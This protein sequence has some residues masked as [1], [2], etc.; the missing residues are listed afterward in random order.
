MTDEVIEEVKDMGTE[1][2]R[3]KIRTRGEERV[4]A[5]ELPPYTLVPSRLRGAYT[6][7][8]LTNCLF[9]ERNNPSK[10]E[11]PR[12]YNV[13]TLD[14]YDRKDKELYSL[15]R[16]YVS[17]GDPTEYDVAMKVFGS[18][19]HWE[20]LCK[21]NWFKPYLKAM[22][23]E[24]RSKIKSEA[25]KQLVEVSINS[26]SDTVRATALRF[27]AKEKV[28]TLE[29]ERNEADNPFVSSSGKR[30]RPSKE[31]IEGNLKQSADEEKKLLQDYERTI[32]LV[33]P[34]SR[35]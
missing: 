18:V 20:V 28:S 31:E 35:K 5:P 6:N 7:S 34:I 30:G 26:E 3:C 17:L 9:Y 32:S 16:L 4:T 2:P 11:D 15:H 33:K 27:L 24:L 10:G 13:F 23:A 19:Y 1:T 25:Y 14:E 21:C 8:Y 12:K 22:R 29:D